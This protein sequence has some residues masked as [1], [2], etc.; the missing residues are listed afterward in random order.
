[1][2]AP[3][4]SAA[5]VSGSRAPP[6]APRSRRRSRQ[7][8][9]GASGV[10]PRPCVRKLGPTLLRE[11]V[12]AFASEAC[13][14]DRPR[15]LR[16]PQQLDAS[17]QADEVFQV[18]RVGPSSAS[19]SVCRSE[20]LQTRSTRAP[21][22]LE[23]K[24]AAPRPSVAPSRRPAWFDRQPSAVAAPGETSLDRVAASEPAAGSFATRRV[25]R[26]V[27]AS[28]DRHNSSTRRA[29][30]TRCFR[31]NALGLRPRRPRPGRPRPWR[32]PPRVPD[33]PRREGRSAATKRCA[34]RPTDAVRPSAPTP[35]AHA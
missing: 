21:D 17:S 4:T 11:A 30:L 5:W 16:P 1:L 19:S 12:C 25:A 34:E 23:E 35:C 29:A 6:L 13:R 28:C 10:A 32:D 18:E 20:T 8:L 24:A 27:R 3:L 14:A 9:A 22:T 33:H 31:S 7:A 15:F 2:A 26:T